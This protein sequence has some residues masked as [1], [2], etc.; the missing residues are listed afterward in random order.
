[1]YFLT[2]GRASAN[3]GGRWY[4]PERIASKGAFVVDAT[5]DTVAESATLLLWVAPALTRLATGETAHGGSTRAD[6]TF[7]NS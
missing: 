2:D 6:S 4:L 7:D 1:M 3:I 5:D